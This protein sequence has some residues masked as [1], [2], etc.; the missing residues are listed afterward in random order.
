MRGMVG[1]EMPGGVVGRISIS[2]RVGSR[3]AGWRVP[4]TSGGWCKMNEA[5]A[6]GQ[7]VGGCAEFGNPDKW[8]LNTVG[9]FVVF[10]S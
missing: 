8:C 5:Q 4:R 2:L 10:F 1:L 9:F 3:C 6:L 7:N